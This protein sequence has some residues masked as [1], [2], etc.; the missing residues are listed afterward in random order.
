MNDPES[1]LLSVFTPEGR[2]DP[3]PALAELR[4][5]EPVHYNAAFDT[6]FLTRYADCQ[7]VLTSSAFAV[8]D[9][10]WCAGEI[11]DWRD[12]PGA[13]F[14]YA[15]MLRSN[16]ADH[17]RLR[18][19]VGGGFSARRVAALRPV[20]SELSSELL[21]GFE[22]AA[23][24][25]LPADDAQDAARG[26]G[27]FQALVAYPLPIAV[28]SRLIGVPRADQDLFQRLGQ[29]AGRLLEP[30][31]TEDD[32]RRADRA[33]VALR[34]YFTDLLARRRCEPADDLTSS[35]LAVRDTDDGRLG[36]SE[37]VDTLILVLVAGF[38]TTAS[39]LGLAVHALLTHEDQWELVRKKPELALGA[40]E[41]VL[42]WD[43]PVRMTERIALRP[44]D[45]GGTTVPAGANVTTVLAAGNR[46]PLRHPDPDTF[47]V[48]REDIKVL[49][50]GSGPHFCIG[51]ALARMEAAEVVGQL[52]RRLPG[53]RLAGP[54]VRRDSISLRAFANLPLATTAAG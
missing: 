45:I 28:A 51:A 20:V 34:A 33:V 26:G 36:E 44:F 52:A 46:D 4:R 10:A 38:E 2:E 19:L 40:V 21:D 11:P 15:S 47:R 37:L 18:R 49:S 12:H 41:E 31:R 53:L 8:P 13:E 27:D 35:L 14:F 7:T 16:G 30:V 50:F 43:A 29:D 24:A 23:G 3:H 6:Y 32:W 42:R 25:T 54:A 48:E 5:R 9:L 22:A 39:L 17:A 1:L